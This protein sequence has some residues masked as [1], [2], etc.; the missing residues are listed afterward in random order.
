MTNEMTRRRFI[1]ALAALTGAAG[2]ILNPDL[3]SLSRAWAE[4]GGLSDTASHDLAVRL[5]RLIYPHDALPDDV[6]AGIIDQ[7]LGNVATGKSFAAQLDAAAA[8]LDERAG[9][10][11]F[12]TDS[13]AQVEAMRSIDTLPFFT[14]ILNQV[15][16][17]LYFSPEYW[18][19]VGYLGPSK[20]FGGYLHHG[21]GD[22]DWLPEE[23]S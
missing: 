20:D 2:S 5:A 21:A 19:H 12:S 6:Y 3:T 10:D 14:A 15:R 11:W 16:F 1:V 18:A 8:A 13:A 22:I 23:S 7:A 9:G 17:G 4:S